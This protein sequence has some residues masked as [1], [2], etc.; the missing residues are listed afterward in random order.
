VTGQLKKFIPRLAGKLAVAFVVKKLSYEGSTWGGQ[1]SELAGAAWSWKQY[2][3]AVGVAMYGGKL[4]GRFVNATEFAEGAWDL[5]LTKAIWTDGIARSQFAVEQFGDGMVQVAPGTGQSWINQGGQYVNL[6][7][8]TLV[9][10]SSLD[11]GT[12]VEASSLDGGTLVEASGMDGAD[13]VYP[14]EVVPVSGEQSYSQAYS[15]QGVYG[16]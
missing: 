16:N 6:Q 4:L 1:T 11:G 12:L 14:G 10:A 7:G 8:G 3:A 5:I 2:A 9:D 15:S 13:V